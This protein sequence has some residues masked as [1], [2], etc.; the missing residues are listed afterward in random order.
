MKDKINL[1]KKIKAL[2]ERG[3]GGE[4]DNAK[5]IL[6]KFM[7]ENGI[8]D[9][10]LEE[11][12]VKHYKFKVPSTPELNNKL[13]HQIVWSVVG[14]DKIYNVKGERSTLYVLC[15]PDDA[16]EIEA[17]FDFYNKLLCKEIDLFYTAFLHKHRIF[18]KDPIKKKPNEISEE[19]ILRLSILQSG[20]S[21]ETYRK[22]LEKG[23]RDV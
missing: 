15:T 3:I 18:G 20:L 2:S 22:R 14:V 6:E 1:A 19:E 7:T 10:D 5:R 9:S 13:F 4:R 17:Q 8:S 12:E 21:D 23:G 16:L 11:T